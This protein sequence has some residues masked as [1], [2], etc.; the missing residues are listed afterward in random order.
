M[1]P[2]YGMSAPVPLLAI[3]TA[4]KSTEVIGAI[5]KPLPVYTTTNWA[6]QAINWGEALKSEAPLGKMKDGIPIL[7]TFRRRG[8]CIVL[9]RRSCKVNGP[10]TQ[11]KKRGEVVVMIRSDNTASIYQARFPISPH[12]AKRESVPSAGLSLTAGQS[13][14]SDEREIPR[15]V[16]TRSPRSKGC[17]KCI[18]H[19]FLTKGGKICL[20]PREA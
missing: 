7:P 14:A 4:R 2:V 12:S 9:V 11:F 5:R 8:I 6:S 18:R 3:H 15:S 1:L 13:G 10:D 17:E 20:T 16:P 19:P